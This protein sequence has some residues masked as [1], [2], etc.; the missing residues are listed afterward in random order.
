MEDKR[1]RLYY[2]QGI[3]VPETPR[4]NQQPRPWKETKIVGKPLPR[5]DAYER[6]SGSAVYPSDVSLPDMLY[7]AILRC[8]HSH[9]RVK[10]VDAS[11][12]RPCLESLR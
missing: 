4:P 2:V 10:S 12:Q 5:V 9:A 7:G 11:R 1:G 6:V 8:P 3:P